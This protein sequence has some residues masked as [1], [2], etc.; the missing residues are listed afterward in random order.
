VRAIDPDSRQTTDPGE[1]RERPAIPE[2]PQLALAGAASAQLATLPRVGSDRAAAYMASLQRGSGNAAVARLLSGGGGRAPLARQLLPGEIPLTGY[3]NPEEGDF[4]NTRMSYGWHARWTPRG[5]G[6]TQTITKPFGSDLY[7]GSLKIKA[8]TSGTLHLHM[9]AHFVIDLEDDDNQHY[10]QDTACNWEVEVDKR[11]KIKLAGNTKPEEFPPVKNEDDESEEDFYITRAALEL[12]ESLEYGEFTMR[13]LFVTRQRSRSD[14]ETSGGGWNFDV[15]IKDYGIGLGG[16]GSPTT[17]EKGVTT[18]PG[19]FGPKSLSIR[20]EPID[21][22]EPQMEMEIG[23]VEVF[24]KREHNVQFRRDTDVAL[25]GAERE[26]LLQW[27]FTLSRKTRRRLREGAQ[28]IRLEGFASN[29][30]PAARN[31]EYYAP[32]RMKAIRTVLNRFIEQKAWIETPIGEDLAIEDDPRKEKSDPG[33]LQARL[34][35]MDDVTPDP[36]IDDDDELMPTK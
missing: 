12:K 18:P 3:G 23:P 2:R 19:S 30:G 9:R 10:F 8:G 20:L 27:Y 29:T 1:A 26:K 25:S 13:P 17:T 6:A 33:M 7:S 16:P 34:E 21:A 22:E 15:T 14:S 24:M 4:D 11:G 5:A 31:A 32:A 35:V 28:K 36:Q